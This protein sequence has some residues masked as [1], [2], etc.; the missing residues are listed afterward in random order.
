MFCHGESQ[1]ENQQESGVT[2]QRLKE[3]GGIAHQRE[4][5]E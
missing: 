1:S 3:L 2:G 4:P 5:L